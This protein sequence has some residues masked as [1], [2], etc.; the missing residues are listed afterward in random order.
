MEKAEKTARRGRRASGSD[1][2][3]R[4]E[5][6]LTRF[7]LG[8]LAEVEEAAS[9]YGLTLASHSRAAQLSVARGSALTV[10]PARSVNR[11]PVEKEAL[12]RILGQL[13]KIGGN[14]NQVARAVNMSTA[15]AAEI[16]A[17]CARCAPWRR[18]SWKRSGGAHDHHAFHTDFGLVAQHGRALLPRSH[19]RAAAPRRLHQRA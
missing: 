11:P 9:R 6:K 13:R 15:D 8:E 18:W 19:N 7:T 3:Q 5:M 10:T 4:T 17:L 2:R 1:K 16:A 14:L 12:A